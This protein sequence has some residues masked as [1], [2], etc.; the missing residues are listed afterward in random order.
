MELNSRV[1]LLLVVLLH[2][3]PADGSILYRVQEEQPPN[4]LIGSLAADQG[5]PDSGHLYKLEV[6]A[7]YLRVDGNTGDIFTTEI[8]IDRET[9]RDCRSPVKSKPCYLEFEVSVTD[10]LQ[11]QSP[12]LI[13]G[14][15]EVQDI[16]DNT[17][18][19][20]LSVLTISVPENTVMGALFSIPVAT[21]RDSER[22]GVADYA[23]TAGPDAATL[24]GLQVA[25]D[26]G[27]KLPQLIVLGNLD[28]ELKD[29]YDLTIKAVDGGNPQRYSQALLRVVVTGR[30]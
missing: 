15:I 16:N 28:R 10:L 19:F 17:P 5:L 6:G 4:T 18:Q 23:L 25:D 7:P 8:P 22:N 20:P 9:L 12:R 26:R 3:G 21:D 24:F 30:Q 2:C 27:G 14:R 13:E 11:N 29:S 1:I